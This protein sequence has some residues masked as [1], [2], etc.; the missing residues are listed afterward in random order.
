MNLLSDGTR[1][2]YIYSSTEKNFPTHTA[3]IL[4]GNLMMSFRVEYSLA[5]CIV[6]FRRSAGRMRIS[7]ALVHRNFDGNMFT[8]RRR[9]IG[10]IR[11]S[12]VVETFRGLLKKYGQ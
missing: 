11:E 12:G 4:S 2:D 3:D 9:N 7:D 6:P 5:F 8:C 10:G 1:G